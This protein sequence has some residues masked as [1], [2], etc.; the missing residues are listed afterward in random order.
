MVR[1]V[2]GAVLSAVVLMVWGVVFWMVLPWGQST[3]KGLPHED[4][5]ARVLRDAV[6]ESG[7][8]YYPYPDPVKMKGHDLAARELYTIRARQGPVFQL[9]YHKEGVD[10][11]DPRVFA[12][13]FA[14]FA[15]ASLLA[16]LLLRAAPLRRYAARVLFVAGAGLFA[17]VAVTL[18]NPI[19]LHHPWPAAL[20]Q[21]AFEVTG[22]LFAGLV[23]GAVVRPAPAALARA[24]VPAEGS[25]SPPAARRSP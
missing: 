22:W 9:V 18:S 19:W 21:A 13:G 8:Y 23:L 12:L 3:I 14:H 24:F 5:V 4:A 17:S 25:L 6:P 11:N 20:V 16:G 7:S 1:L 15:A 2:G 10:T